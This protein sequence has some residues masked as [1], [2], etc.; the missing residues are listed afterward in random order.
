MTTI[1]TPIGPTFTGEVMASSLAGLPFSWGDDGVYYGEDFPP[2]R[3]A[4]LE[5][6]VAAHDP[7]KQLPREALGKQ[8]AAALNDLGQLEA[9]DAAVNAAKPEDRYYWMRSY[10]DLVPEDNA[11]L[12]RIAAAAGVDVAALF[13][14][15]MTEPAK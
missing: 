2:E 1:A 12:G 10:D 3:V 4:D 5:A 14:K 6:L 9:W 15:A 11:K 8:I 7:A 13:D